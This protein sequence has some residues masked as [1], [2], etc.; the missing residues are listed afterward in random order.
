M[1]KSDEGTEFHEAEANRLVG[2]E[3]AEVVEVAADADGVVAVGWSF[4]TQLCRP[5]RPAVV[6]CTLE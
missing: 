3:V 5:V 1:A 2:A 6:N 4:G